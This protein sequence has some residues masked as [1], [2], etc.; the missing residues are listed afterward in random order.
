M[1][2]EGYSAEEDE[3]AGEMANVQMGWGKGAPYGG[4]GKGMFYSTGK[5]YGG[6]KGGKKG[7]WKG[8]R[9]G[10]RQ[11]QGQNTVLQAVLPLR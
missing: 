2:Q 11:G 4:K 6:K 9:E 3:Y 7:N 10:K 8:V 5:G 1:S